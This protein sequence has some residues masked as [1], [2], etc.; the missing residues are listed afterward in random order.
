LKKS[1]QKKIITLQQLSE[2]K[3]TKRQKQVIFEWNIEALKLT[4]K[5]YIANMYCLDIKE[6]NG[7]AI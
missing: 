5:I 1:N 4:A 6:S 3:K 7:R 2:V